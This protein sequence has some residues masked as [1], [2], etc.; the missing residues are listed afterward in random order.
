MWS[1]ALSITSLAICTLVCIVALWRGTWALRGA[2]ALF[3]AGWWVT[4][5]AYELAG[6][7]GERWFV[8]VIDVVLAVGIA[9]IACLSGRRWAMAM[10]AFQILTA[11]THAA[12]IIDLRFGELAY[13]ALQVA[14]TIGALMALAIGVIQ[15]ELSRRGRT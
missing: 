7:N 1:S 4:P 11:A 9:T 5:M 2:A 13:W 6:P 14:Y 12:A 15:H 8:L 3:L 10:A